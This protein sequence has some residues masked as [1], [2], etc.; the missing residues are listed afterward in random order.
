MYVKSVFL[1]CVMYMHL[2]ISLH[3]FPEVLQQ[4]AIEAGA[5][6]VVEQYLQHYQL[7]DGLCNMVLVTIGSLT[8]S[9]NNILPIHAHKCTPHICMFYDV[10]VKH[11]FSVHVPN[12]KFLQKEY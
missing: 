7:E 10:G 12:K 1:G 9:G 2:L 8:D 3:F 5:L 4:K 11:S 6:D